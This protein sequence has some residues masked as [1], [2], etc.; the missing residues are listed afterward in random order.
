MAD[1]VPSPKAEDH[2]TQTHEG[3]CLCGAVR[4]RLTGAL[5][6]VFGCHCGQ[7][8]KISGHYVAATA[9][10]RESFQL[11]SGEETLSWFE[12][13]PGVRRGFCASCGSNLFWDRASLP[14]I[15]VMAGS[16]DEPS[17]LTMKSHM[18]VAYKGDYYELN[19]GLPQKQER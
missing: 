1:P 19:D 7:C 6:P 18:F 11:L 14:V 10:D 17:G 5:R 4:Y 13:S 9:V 3:G 16:I 15:A 2:E 8:R 12:S